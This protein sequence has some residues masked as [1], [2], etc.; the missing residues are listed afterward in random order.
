MAERIG[1]NEHYEEYAI[2]DYEWPFELGEYISIEEINR[3]ADMIEELPEY[4]QDN[5][6]DLMSYFSNFD[7]LYGHQDDI[8]HYPDC[9]CMAHVAEYVLTESGQLGTLPPDLRDY[10]DFEAYGTMLYTSGSFVETRD[11]IFEICT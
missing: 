10:I 2:H 6:E 4:I 7:E 11:G 3:L 8:I 1:L 9:D 5:I